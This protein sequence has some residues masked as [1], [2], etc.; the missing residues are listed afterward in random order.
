MKNFWDKVEMLPCEPGCWLW[1]GSFG[2]NGYGYFSSELAHRHS[3][4]LANGA[5]P[6]GLCV[7]HKCDVRSCVNPSH[8]FLGSHADNTADM[9]KKGRGVLPPRFIGETN[10]SSKLTAETV[11]LIRIDKRS[12]KVV[13]SEYGVSN[14]LVGMIRRRLA[15][16]HIQ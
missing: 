5:I 1:T 8:L 13:A 7:L 14:V 12:N 16:R 11:R 10:K 15:W 9:F 2:N 6:R 3:W 4:G